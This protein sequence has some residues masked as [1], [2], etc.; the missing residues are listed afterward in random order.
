ML[1]NIQIL[2]ITFIII[3]KIE[4]AFLEILKTY[5]PNVTILVISWSIIAG[6]LT[7]AYIFNEIL[8]VK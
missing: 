2:V 8:E 1:E 7:L 3:V 4:M 5:N 6:S